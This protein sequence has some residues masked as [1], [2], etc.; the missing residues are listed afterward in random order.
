MVRVAL[1]NARLAFYRSSPPPDTVVLNYDIEVFVFALIRFLSG[2]RATRIVVNTFILTPRRS[3]ILNAMRRAYYSAVLS[4]VD[5]AIVHSRTE[6]T[7]YA[8]LFPSTHFVFVPYGLSVDAASTLIAD[9]ITERA[10]HIRPVIVTAGRSARDYPTL[11]AAIAGL[12]VELRVICDVRAAIPPLPEDGH[13]VILDRCYGTGYL[14]QVAAADI[15]VVPLAADDISA[16]QMVM[17]QAWALNRPVIV[18]DTLTIREYATDGEDAILV[19]PRDPAALRAA[20]LRI[21]GDP[22][23][24]E[25]LSAHG[26]RTFLERHSTDAVLRGVVSAIIERCE[27]ADA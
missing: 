23:C 20:I 6:V 17:L 9:S 11:F 19:S 18:T 1:D 10:A 21:L 22:A 5:L 3:L 26:A 4:F 14:R 25:A 12:D 15:V 2:H 24:G 8:V 13:V 27:L 16:G 7:R